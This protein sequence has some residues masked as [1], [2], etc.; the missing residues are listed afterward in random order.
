MYIIILTLIQQLTHLIVGLVASRL[1][2]GYLSLHELIRIHPHNKTY[3]I[4]LNLQPL[5]SLVSLSSLVLL[6]FFN[7][8]IECDFRASFSYAFFDLVFLPTATHG[9][10][11]R[12]V[13]N[14]L[15]RWRFQL[16]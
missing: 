3:K 14:K 2:I 1:N 15:A 4:V 7:N 12:R 10:D 6:L 9:F 8:I 11:W 13:S 16:N 5:Y